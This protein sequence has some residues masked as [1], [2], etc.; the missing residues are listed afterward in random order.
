MGVIKFSKS[1]KVLI[2]GI[3]PQR[4]LDERNY[5]CGMRKQRRNMALGAD[6]RRE[7]LAGWFWESVGED[8]DLVN[9]RSFNQKIQWMK[10]NDSTPEKG[11]LADKYLVREFIES[12]IG[13]GYLVPLLGVWDDP[14][15]IDF[16]KLPDRFALKATHGC[17][18]NIIVPDKAKL[19]IRRARRDLSRWLGLDFAYCT[20]GLELHYSYCEPRIIAEEFLDTGGLSLVDYKVHMFNDGEPIIL[21]CADRVAGQLPKKA[22]YTPEWER[23]PLREGDSELFDC[24][25]P[26]RLAEMMEMSRV[27]AD[28][29]PFVRVDWYVVRGKLYF[30]EMTFTPASGAKHF[31]PGEWNY[32]FGRRIAL[33][34]MSDDDKIGEGHA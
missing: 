21:V 22:Y 18:W 33:P 11:R 23:L 20:D 27:L 3:C 9:P 10:L 15:D 4:L 24:P 28:G 29:F 2:K 5:I 14:D 1:F 12:K 30:G 26:P 31:V 17:G 6:G 32:E 19:D 16:E 8:L 25:K 7:I 34:G 13:D